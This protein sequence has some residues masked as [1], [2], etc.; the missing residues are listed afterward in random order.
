MHIDTSLSHVLL[1]EQ[2]NLSRQSSSTIQAQALITP[3]PSKED[4]V[5]IEE[6]KRTE[7]K[8]IVEFQGIEINLE[9]YENSGEDEA[10]DI[11]TLTPREMVD[12]SL[13]LYINGSLSYDEYS[14][15]AF[16][17]EL[18]PHFEGTIGALTGERAEPDR[19]RDFIQ[20]WEDRYNFERRYPSED[21][22]T[23]Q[24]I[25]RILGVLSA[26]EM[27]TDFTA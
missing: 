2:E 25:E 10:L 22:R 26:H 16:Q 11:R 7:P 1:R 23:L 8:D 19:P 27:A 12:I 9:D 3:A 17:A 18:H 14:M 24:Q 13:D 4:L 15:L 5:R 6:S 20:E 21:P